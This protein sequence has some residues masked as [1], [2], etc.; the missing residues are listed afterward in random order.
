MTDVPVAKK[1][2]K[3]PILCLI[4][5]SIFLALIVTGLYSLFGRT[6]DNPLRVSNAVSDA[7]PEGAAVLSYSGR[8]VEPPEG[9]EF[10]FET[11]LADQL[12][13]TYTF[14]QPPGPSNSA[15]QDV[16]IVEYTEPLDVL[17]TGVE[18]SEGLPSFTELED[19]VNFIAE[20]ENA[21]RQDFTSSVEEVDGQ[22]R[23][24]QSYTIQSRD[25]GADEG[26]I[27]IVNQAVLMIFDEESQL[28]TQILV[29]SDDDIDPVV[30]DEFLMALD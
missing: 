25:P 10:L 23:A 14:H 5:I 8:I 27:Q 15:A 13:N 28:R 6:D 21:T 12:I 2:L 9:Y 1:N 26:D 29:S 3:K 16:T 17:L 4:L 20:S 22:F 18:F 19:Y 11:Q 30:L 7:I 24:R